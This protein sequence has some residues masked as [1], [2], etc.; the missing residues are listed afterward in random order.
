M[1]PTAALNSF[2]HSIDRLINRT[3]QEEAGGSE[4]EGEA[5]S[6]HSVKRIVTVASNIDMGTPAWVQGLNHSGA[7][8]RLSGYA[9]TQTKQ[10]HP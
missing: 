1:E 3:K 2:E 7:S 9:L 5:G 4:D 8:C 10:Q 6:R